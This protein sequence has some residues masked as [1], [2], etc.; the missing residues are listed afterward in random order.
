VTDVRG[1]L[2]DDALWVD[3]ESEQ[4]CLE[5]EE[6][7]SAETL[8]E[9]A[10]KLHR[11]AIVID[12]HSDILNPLADGRCRLKDR[13][14]VESP[15]SWKSAEQVEVRIRPTPYQLSSYATWFQCIGQYDIP[16]FREGGVTAQV[17][18]IYVDDDF[19]SAPLERALDMVATLYRELESN[20]ESLLLATT[21]GDI[22][23][24]KAEGKIALV[25][26]F[27]GAEPLG[28]DLNLVEIFYRLGVR[29]ISLTHSRRNF[30]ADGTQVGV[31]TGGLTHLGRD[32]IRRMNELG[33]VIDLAHLG[34]TSFWEVLELSQDPLIVSHTSVCR[35]S[36]EYCASFTAV[37]T[38]RGTSKLKALADKGGVVGIIFWGQPDIDA[39]VDEIETVIQYVGDDHV[40]LGSDLYG[41]DRAP[42]GLEDISKLPTLTEHLV[43]RGYGDETIL[44]VLGGNLMRVFEEVL[45]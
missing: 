25:L 3:V 15:E 42:Q 23:R 36:S 31:T 7:L 12:G 14:I 39:I 5:Q 1:R 35:S 17:M 33:M 24:A 4:A 44:K 34:D 32:V 27:E 10:R 21:V 41:L 8:L 45:G 13:V 6:C 20:P 19:L 28:R 18:A 38:Q 2:G 29:M 22:R 43:K 9:H 11:Q 26:S 37:N 30:L 40:S 16:R